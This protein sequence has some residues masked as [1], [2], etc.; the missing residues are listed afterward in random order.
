MDR[1][2]SLAEVN[3]VLHTISIPT[4]LDFDCSIEMSVVAL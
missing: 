3:G 4:E 1:D 2:V